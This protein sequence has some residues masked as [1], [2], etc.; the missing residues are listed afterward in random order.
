MCL[1]VFR[2]RSMSRLHVLRKASMKSIRMMHQLTPL[3]VEVLQFLDSYDWCS[4]WQTRSNLEFSWIGHWI[5]TIALQL[6]QSK[7]KQ[8][9]RRRL[10]TDH[11]WVVLVAWR[12]VRDRCQSSSLASWKVHAVQA[13]IVGSDAGWAEAGAA[14]QDHSRWVTTKI[15]H[16]SLHSIGSLTRLLANDLTVVWN[17][18]VRS[19]P[20]DMTEKGTQKDDEGLVSVWYG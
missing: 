14:D 11:V 9:D 12:S 7:F 13:L 2:L 6:K 15:D 19:R 17:S 20:F 5:T 3:P 8:E 16:A 4:A 18:P 10:V 1:R